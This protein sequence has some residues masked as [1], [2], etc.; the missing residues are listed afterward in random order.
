[1]GRTSQYLR[2]RCRAYFD[3]THHRAH[4]RK[5]IDMHKASIA[6]VALVALALSR[7]HP[8]TLK[9]RDAHGPHAPTS[10]RLPRCRA[11]R[12]PEPDPFA[13]VYIVTSSTLYKAG[14]S[15]SARNAS[16]HRDSVGSDLVIAEV[17]AHR[18][19][20]F[21]HFVHERE[22]RCGGYFAFAT[23]AEAE[24]FL[25]T[26]RSAQAVFPKSI[27]QHPI[28]NQAT[29]SPWLQKYPS[30]HSRDPAS[31]H[32]PPTATTRATM[33]APHW[34]RDTARAGRARD[35]SAE[36]FIACGIAH[37]AQIL[38]AGQR[39]RPRDRGRADT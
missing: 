7:R 33:D 4:I 17:Q 12:S 10:W 16:H 3:R 1:M 32:R 21:S 2:L 15:T 14:L 19:A 29:V 13:P 22:K 23:R 39:P 25:R 28:D 38:T 26:E 30:Q 31:L 18:L 24:A 36:L 11:M 37:P 5:R 6:S 20:D 35:V 27:L 8:P 34:I 9:A